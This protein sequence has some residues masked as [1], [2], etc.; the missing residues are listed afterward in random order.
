MRPPFPSS[1]FRQ[2]VTLP[3]PNPLPLSCT[4]THTHPPTHTLFYTLPQTEHKRGANDFPS[5]PVKNGYIE[6]WFEERFSQTLPSKLHDI[7]GWW[8]CEEGGDTLKTHKGFERARR[9]CA[10]RVGKGI[11]TSTPSIH[12]RNK[13]CLISRLAA[14]LHRRRRPPPPPQNTKEKEAEVFM[15]GNGGKTKSISLEKRLGYV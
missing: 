8:F 1:L 12:A 3:T 15:T 14:A 2:N 5:I 6:W 13:F 9:G 4:H 11:S 10:S 7:K